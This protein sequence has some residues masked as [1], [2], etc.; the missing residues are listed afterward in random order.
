ML[1]LEPESTAACL[2][3]FYDGTTSPVFPSSSNSGVPAVV[4]I[5]TMGV[6]TIGASFAAVLGGRGHNTNLH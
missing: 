5:A 2:P 6:E 1:K 3:C 4:A